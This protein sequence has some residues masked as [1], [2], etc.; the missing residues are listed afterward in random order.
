MLLQFSR[1]A[2]QPLSHLSVKSLNLFLI[3]IFV[4]NLEDAVGGLRHLCFIPDDYIARR[5]A[6]AVEGLVRLQML[7]DDSALE[8]RAGEEAAASRAALG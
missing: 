1:F 8:F 6:L 4:Q 2:G 7:G 3:R 5:E